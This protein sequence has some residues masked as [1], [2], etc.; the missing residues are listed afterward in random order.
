M[1]ALLNM[2]CMEYM[3]SLPDHTFD[4]AIVD[5]PYRDVNSPTK[6]MRN[7]L[8]G[9]MKDFGNKPDS[10]FFKELFRVSK[11]QIVWGANNFFNILP[12]T[13]CF[14][15]WDK[16]MELANYADGELA[17]TSFDKVAKQ[18]RYVWSGNRYGSPDKIEGVGKPTIRIHPTEKPIALYK[19]LLQTYAAPGDK[20]LDTHLGSGSSAIAAHMMGFD[21]VGTEIDKDYFDAAMKRYNEAIKQGT[22][23]DYSIK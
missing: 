22:L 23:F 2:D 9:S 6:E 3:A 1:I 16:V 11:N 8:N 18:F 19:W 5:P 14:I 20:I 10:I 12:A 17:W 21:F 4:L 7:K 15:F 13:N